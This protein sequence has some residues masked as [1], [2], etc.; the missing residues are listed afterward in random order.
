[1]WNVSVRTG[2][3]DL[4]ILGQINQCPETQ[5]LQGGIYI[6]SFA[7]A[8]FRIV[9]L[10]IVVVCLD[11]GITVGCRCGRIGTSSQRVVDVIAAVSYLM[12]RSDVVA[13]KIE[14][15]GEGSAGPVA[16]H[17]AALDPRISQLKRI[18]SL[19]TWMDVVRQPLGRNQLTN[20][21]SF[22]LEYY[23]L[24]HLVQAIAPRLVEVVE[25]VDA[26]GHV[27]Q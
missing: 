12:S 7:D 4:I 16:L 27:K 1:M 15:I 26:L 5:E 6:A 8:S 18:R 2:S 13:G 22:A 3:L 17:A 25:P 10:W 9:C 19:D 20:I 24:P 21:V 23:D 11:A 14:L